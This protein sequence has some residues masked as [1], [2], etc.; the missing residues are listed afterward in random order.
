M[1]HFRLVNPEAV[2]RSSI[3]VYCAGK[4]STVFGFERMK[5]P[6]GLVFRTA[7][8]DDIQAFRFWRPDAKMCPAVAGRLCPDRIA[9]LNS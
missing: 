4:I 5:S 9:A 8:Q 6:L 7:F 3:R 1:K 2:E